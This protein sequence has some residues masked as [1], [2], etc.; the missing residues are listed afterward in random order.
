MKYTSIHTVEPNLMLEISGLCVI[1]FLSGLCFYMLYLS[2]TI[3][4][5]FKINHAYQQS[6]FHFNQLQHHAKINQ[7]V[8]IALKIK[9]NQNPNA[10]HLAQQ[11]LSEN[12]LLKMITENAYQANLVLISEKPNLKNTVQLNLTGS[13]RNLFELFYLL[14]NLSYPISLVSIELKQEKNLKINI[15]A[16]EENV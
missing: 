8:I 13:F 4:D 15:V 12:N 2:H 1:I 10:F 14:D 6:S 9:R 11:S 5:Y 3:H 16:R 7:A